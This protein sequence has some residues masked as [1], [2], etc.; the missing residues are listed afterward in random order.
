MCNNGGSDVLNRIT[1]IRGHQFTTRRT[2]IVVRQISCWGGH[3]RWPEKCS[4][5]MSGRK[6]PP[7]C[8]GRWG[9][10]FWDPTLRHSSMALW[11]GRRRGGGLQM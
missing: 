5:R 6:D 4:I 2:M 8:F 1:G 11:C 10:P 9:G 3:S 7:A